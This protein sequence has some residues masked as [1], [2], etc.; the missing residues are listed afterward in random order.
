MSYFKMIFDAGKVIWSIAVMLKVF[1]WFYK[2]VNGKDLVV[3]GMKGAGK[4]RF[5]RYLQNKPFIE[6]STAREEYEEF[7]FRKK[8]AIL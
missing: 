2:E 6:S 3:L 1:G 4:T 5:Y 8:M 7:E